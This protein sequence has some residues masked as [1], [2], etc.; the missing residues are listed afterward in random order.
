MFTIIGSTTADLL[1]FS[2]TPLTGLGGDGFQAGNLVFTDEPLTLLLGGNGGNSAYVL[3]GL[4]APVALCS[5]VGRDVWG[6]TLAG[7][8]AERQVD[9]TGLVRS[10]TKATS[11]STIIQTHAAHQAVFHHLGAT[12]EIRPET[13]PLEQL[14][15]TGVLLISSWPI[16]P[17]M[18]S[19][20]IAQ[21][22]RVVRQAGGITAVDIGPAIDQPVLLPEL[23][24][25]LPHIDYLIANSY[26]LG[27]LT[28]AADRELAADRL[29][30]AGARQ[31]IIK[32]GDEG[33]SIRGQA[34]QVDVP[35][36]AVKAKISVGAGDSFNAGFLYG[37]QQGWSLTEAA[38]FGN[39]VAALVVSG[40]QGVL[41]APGLP[42]VKAFIK[43]RN[44]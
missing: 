22:L 23:Q 32:R 42:Q 16:M 4:E 11:S 25:I 44:G 27:L 8:L 33:V 29:L 9:L 37:V 15:Q 39:A 2:Q 31:V 7:W 1:I 43:E 6:D 14:Q 38:Q 5:A 10:S 40:E 13:I 19:G 35:G 24:P 20:G 36:F 34:E 28:G 21:T 17:G 30:E 12:V 41:G 26:E 18:R 3:A